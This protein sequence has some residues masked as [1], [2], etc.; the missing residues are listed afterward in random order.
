[1]KKKLRDIEVPE[2]DEDAPPPEP[3]QK[4]FVW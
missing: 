2:P 3:Q 1:M 4:G